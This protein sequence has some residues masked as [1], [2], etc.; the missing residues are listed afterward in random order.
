MTMIFKVPR[1]LLPSNAKMLLLLYQN[2]LSGQ[3]KEYRFCCFI[4]MSFS[5][6]NQCDAILGIT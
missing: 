4:V 1:E 6:K 3:L 2:E 5:L